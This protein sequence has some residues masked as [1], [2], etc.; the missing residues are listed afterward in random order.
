MPIFGYDVDGGVLPP[1]RLP[2]PNLGGRPPPA[3]QVIKSIL[4]QLTSEP[5]ARHSILRHRR[6][7]GNLP[8]QNWWAVRSFFCLTLDQWFWF[9]STFY[10]GIKTVTGS[11]F[12]LP[13]VLLDSKLS[14]SN[15]ELSDYA[16]VVPK[17]LPLSAKTPSRKKL[18]NAYFD[19]V[20]KCRPHPVQR[21]KYLCFTVWDWRVRQTDDVCRTNYPMGNWAAAS[22]K[23][24]IGH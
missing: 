1:D 15:F 9:S 12:G 23:L 5:T 18:A 8:F 21:P 14:R 22:R 17:P 19:G 2:I 10:E 20:I 11:P 3:A 13:L 6:R 24:Q 7:H 16:G 4:R